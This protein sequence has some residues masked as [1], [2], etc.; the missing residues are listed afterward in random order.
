MSLLQY[1]L[2]LPLQSTSQQLWLMCVALETV[3][4]TVSAGKVSIAPK[5]KLG[6]LPT[7][8]A[9]TNCS[10]M[11]SSRPTQRSVLFSA[12]VVDAG[13]SIL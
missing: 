4:G 12:A 8:F 13:D 11:I 6:R 2:R 10:S 1:S 7:A 9:A 3:F 5:M